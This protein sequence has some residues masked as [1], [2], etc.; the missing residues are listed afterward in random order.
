MPRPASK[1]KGRNLATEDTE[2]T[3]GAVERSTA[4]ALSGDEAGGVQT[5]VDPSIRLLRRL[6]RAGGGWWT[7][8]SGQINRSAVGCVVA[9]RE[10]L[11]VGAVS[12]PRTDRVD[13]RRR[14]RTETEGVDQLGRCLCSIGVIRHLDRRGSSRVWCRSPS[15][16]AGVRP[17]CRRGQV[18]GRGDSDSRMTR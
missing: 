18:G 12:G 7:E 9:S 4:G 8:D 5:T 11:P 10:N 15:L 2:H 1:N 14:Q 13:G 6:L 16:W 3:E 17:F